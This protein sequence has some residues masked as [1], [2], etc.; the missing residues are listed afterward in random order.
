MG[1]KERHGTKQ[2]KWFACSL[3][4][5]NAPWAFNRGE[6][7]R[8]IASL[9]FLGALVGVM[10]LL[11]ENEMDLNSVGMVTLTCGTDNQGNGYLL[12]KLLTTKYPLAVIL[13]ELSCQLG[14]RG[15]S[16]RARWI[17]RLQNEEADALANG[18]YRHFSC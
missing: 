5:S 14:M 3:D 9:E 4:R 13:M 15:A 18:D 2:S 8:T 16:M 11:P 12:D 17:P 10:V 1:H 7:F 6:A